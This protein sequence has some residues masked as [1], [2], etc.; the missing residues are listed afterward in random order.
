MR[1][2]NFFEIRPAPEMQLQMERA[3]LHLTRCLRTLPR[4]A[5]RAKG[6]GQSNAGQ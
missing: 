6:S 1:V 5:A 3:G 2:S 4:G